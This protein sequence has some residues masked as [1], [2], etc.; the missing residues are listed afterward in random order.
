[1]SSIT[2]TYTVTGVLVGEEVPSEEEAKLGLES[3]SKARGS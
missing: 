1:M 3:C 2:S